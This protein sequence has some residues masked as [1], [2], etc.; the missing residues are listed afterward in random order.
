ME[1]FTFLQVILIPTVIE[2]MEKYS[3]SRNSR[4]SNLSILF[5]EASKK[6]TPSIEEMKQL[7]AITNTV[8]TNK[9]Q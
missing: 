8:E 6:L 2:C 5:L 4:L 1:T 9:M 7:N 3:S